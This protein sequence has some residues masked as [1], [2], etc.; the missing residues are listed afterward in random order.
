MHVLVVIVCFVCFC[1]LFFWGGGGGRGR[2]SQVRCA[3]CQTAAIIYMVLGFR[4]LRLF[5]VHGFMVL[6]FVIRSCGVVRAPGNVFQGMVL[7]N[8]GNSV[9]L[10]GGRPKP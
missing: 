9:S 7:R 6:G 2:G 10:K 4:V 5:R 8:V 1:F 3:R